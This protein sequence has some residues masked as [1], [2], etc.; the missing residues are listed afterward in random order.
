MTATELCQPWTDSLDLCDLDSPDPALVARALDVASEIM[1]HAS[2][3]QFRGLCTDVVRPCGSG[4]AWQW[5]ERPDGSGHPVPLHCEC[6][7]IGASSGLWCDCSYHDAVTLPNTPVV[8]VTE[9]LIDGQA[10]AADGWKIVDNRWLIRSPRR[11]WP[12][13]QRLDLDPTEPGTWQVTYTW[14]SPVPETGKAAVEELA[15]ELVKAWTPGEGCRLPKRV[16]Q[17]TREGV[18]WTLLDT[19]DDLL[20]QGYGLTLVA[21][22][23]QTFNPGKLQRA[24]RAVNART[25]R[26]MPRRVR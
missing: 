3:R 20:W 16:T 10:V 18:S 17:V 12:C 7:T 6:P 25:V 5:V 23:V 8:E 14:G 11:A 13:C 22:F 4:W 19:F 26:S 24:G 15:C 21:G 2:G 9:V 1:F